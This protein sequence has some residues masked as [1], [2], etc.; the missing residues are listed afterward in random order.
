[1]T[2]TFHKSNFGR[3]GESLPCD[4]DGYV[5]LTATGWRKAGYS[6][7]DAKERAEQAKEAVARAEAALDEWRSRNS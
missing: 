3:Y 4:Q 5:H 7:A 1:M 6:K 2:T